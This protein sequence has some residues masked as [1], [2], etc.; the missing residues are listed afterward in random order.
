[1]T[2]ILVSALGAGFCTGNGFTISKLL[3]QK[4]QAFTF[5]CKNSQLPNRQN[6]QKI[7]AKDSSSFGS[8][9]D[10]I[11]NYWKHQWALLRPYCYHGL[12]HVGTGWVLAA[13][14]TLFLLQISK[15]AY[16]SVSR[17]AESS[18]YGHL[19][20]EVGRAFVFFFNQELK[21]ASHVQDCLGVLG[22]GGT[23]TFPGSYHFWL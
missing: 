16:S 12:I 23:R 11:M 8:V 18:W 7:W 3:I 19:H 10:Q 1:M 20:T 5:L 22:L 17:R 13:L 4:F 15:N 9:S 6:W 2:H 21:I 14:R